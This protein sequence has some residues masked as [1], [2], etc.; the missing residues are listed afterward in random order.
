MLRD[1]VIDANC[2]GRI[3]NPVA[4]PYKQLIEWLREHGYLCVSRHLLI[5]YAKAGCGPGAQNI[6]AILIQLLQRIG[7]LIN[8][9]DAAL[10]GV[11]F[12]KKIERNLLS[13]RSDWVHI[14]LVMCSHRRLLISS[15][16]KLR[17]DVRDFPRFKAVAIECPSEVNLTTYIPDSD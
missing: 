8:I 10:A 15:D 7:R 14:K 2:A 16:G 6:L 11:P 4:E 9:N 12:T 5:E 13:N 17:R 1:I 3:C